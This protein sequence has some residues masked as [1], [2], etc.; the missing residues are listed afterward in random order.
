MPNIFQAFRALLPQTPLQ[1]GTVESVGSGVVTLTLPGGGA[2]VVR[3]SAAV[4]DRVFFRDGVVESVA[5]AL[6]AIEIE[7]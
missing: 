7:V 5:P 3:G 6:E 1:A 4:G 2:V